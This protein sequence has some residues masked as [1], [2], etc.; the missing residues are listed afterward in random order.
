M[1]GGH[2]SLVTYWL[3]EDDIPL[4]ERNYTMEAME[5]IRAQ[6][7]GELEG[8]RRRRWLAPR[9]AP[10]PAD[11]EGMFSLVKTW[12][13]YNYPGTHGRGMGGMTRV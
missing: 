6:W 1:T 4:L 2:P 11:W 5:R 8:A 3:S 10:G 12:R 9:D 7:P 13:Y